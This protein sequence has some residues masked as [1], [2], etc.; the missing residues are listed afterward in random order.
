MS[1]PH[2][3]SGTLGRPTKAQSMALG[4][5]STGG[6]V[7][8]LLASFLSVPAAAQIATENQELKP[9]SRVQGEAVVQAAWELRKGLDPK[10]DCSHFVHSVYQQAGLDYDYANS[11]A[12]YDGIPAFQRVSR[13][14]PGDLIAWPGH[15]G[16]IIDPEEHSFYSSVVKGYALEDYRSK[17]W[18]RHGHPHFYR[19]L[20]DETQSARLPAHAQVAK[21]EFH[22]AQQSTSVPRVVSDDDD[23]RSDE[24]NVRTSA[25]T[26]AGNTDSADTEVSDIVFVS[27]RSRPLASEVRS[28]AIRASGVHG[29]HGLQNGLSDSQ[30]L[31]VVDDFTVSEIKIQGRSGWATIEVKETA[32]IQNGRAYLQRRSTKWRVA[33]HREAQGWVM[34]V[35][36]ELSCLPREQAIQALTAHLAHLAHDS[37]NEME[38]KR[39]VRVLDDLLAA[40]RSYTP[41]SGSD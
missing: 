21:K 5:L 3:T 30:P 17:Y 18:L 29:K 40:E 12:I 32:S 19:F 10:P 27:S 4:S 31:S 20:I 22:S 26:A 35:P 39:I 15:V 7:T 16:I 34:I 36:R 25:T 11:V 14:Q 1:A 8:S 28:A 9:V 6:V 41:V 33:L 37:D 2:L 13:P 23:D 38:L 24:I